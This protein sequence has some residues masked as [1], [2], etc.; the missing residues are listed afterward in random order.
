MQ[1]RLVCLTAALFVLSA[2]ADPAAPVSLEVKD[3]TPRFVAFY[4]ASEHVRG[5]DGQR[6]KL[7]QSF[8]LLDDRK[9]GDVRPGLY[10]FTDG[11]PEFV[12][13]MPFIRQGAG[14]L[15]PMPDEALRRIAALLGAE[16]PV[17]VT[18]TTEVRTDG[19]KTPT[20]YRDLQ[21]V[22]IILPFQDDPR[23]IAIRMAQAMTNAVLTAMGTRDDALSHTVGAAVLQ[24]GLGLR[25]A[26]S[27]F[28]D[29]TELDVI[30]PYPGAYADAPARRTQILEDIRKA[31]ADGSDRLTERAGPAGLTC[32]VCYAGWL[33]TG[34]WLAHGESFA[35]IARVKEADAPARVAEAIDLMLEEP[36][37]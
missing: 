20:I 16:V 15:R 17:R 33:V 3:L 22:V 5:G 28:P 9:E 23:R 37:R 10:A 25:V 35:E 34:F 18:L 8:G 12:A 26:R 27:L 31:R 36:R 11:W 7:A 14:A 13:A 2:H 4:D 19:S 30:E 29:R 32:E 24:T 6:I 21:G 1:G